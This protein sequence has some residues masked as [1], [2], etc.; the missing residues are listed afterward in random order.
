MAR[1]Y[2]ETECALYGTKYCEALNMVNCGVCT[3]RGAAD[4]DMQ[5][6]M[7]D[8]DTIEALLPDGGISDLF[9]DEQC[10]LCKGETRNPRK[11]YALSDLGHAEPKRRETG[12]LGI[13]RA[14]K[15]GSILPVQLSCCG[16][17]RCRFLTAEYLPLSVGLMITAGALAALSF[18]ALR[19]AL[20]TLTPALPFLVFIAAALVGLALGFLLRKFLLKRFSKHTH[21]NI[22]GLP[23]LIDMRRR[24]WFE[25]Y[26]SRGASKII[27]SRNRLKQG[28]F[29]GGG[30]RE[31]DLPES[32]DDALP[33]GGA[34]MLI[35]GAE[36]LPINDE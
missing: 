20:S 18:R 36:T 33:S 9:T 17:C 19:E 32:F 11:W 22:F 12:F 24:G 8:I 7:R 13:K 21:M 2:N 30:D 29:T 15:M 35:E 3:V 26:E 16:K 10:V 31:A 6:I 34:E 4:G 25:L 1:Y 23:K 28:L 27:F 14:A 5:S